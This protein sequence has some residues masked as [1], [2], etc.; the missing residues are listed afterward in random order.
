MWPYDYF[1]QFSSLEIDEGIGSKKRIFL[2]TWFGEKDGTEK[3][4]EHQRNRIGYIEKVVNSFKFEEDSYELKRTRDVGDI[5]SNIMMWTIESSVI[6]CDIT[7][8]MVKNCDTSQIC[9][10]YRGN[11]LF[12]LGLAM[13]WKMEEQVILLWDKNSAGEFNPAYLPTD[14]P[15]KWVSSVNSSD[16]KEFAIALSNLLQ[17]RLTVCNLRKDIL[18]QNAKSRLDERSLVF[19]DRYFNGITRG[20]GLP[21]ASKT[22]IVAESIISTIRHLLNLNLIKMDPLPNRTSGSDNISWCYYLTGIGRIVLS[23]ELNRTLFPKILDDIFRVRHPRYDPK[24]EFK[25]RLEIFERNYELD[26]WLTVRGFLDVISPNGQG[27]KPLGSDRSRNEEFWLGQ[28][29]KY[30]ETA[31]PQKYLDEVDKKW[32]GMF[33]SFRKPRA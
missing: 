10:S 15:T 13:G 8:T 17:S 2:S 31:S 19:F 26:Y 22:D 28:F 6:I 21:D 24:G 7:P 32:K 3:E 27:G 16:E 25:R 1:H 30:F 12:E 5:F 33:V 14:I 29:G 4:R 9:P 23:K 18:V 11:V 20:F